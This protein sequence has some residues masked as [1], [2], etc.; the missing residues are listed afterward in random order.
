MISP[1]TDQ[2][3][4]EL[5]AAAKE[6]LLDDEHFDFDEKQRKLLTAYGSLELHSE[7]HRRAVFLC[8][9]AVRRVLRFGRL[10]TPQHVQD[11]ADAINLV[12]R[13]LVEVD[14]PSPAVWEKF[15]QLGSDRRDVVRRDDET[16]YL[17]TICFAVSALVRFALFAGLYDGIEALTYSW[18]A[19]EG[20]ADN[21]FD[22]DGFAR[23]MAES[24]IAAAYRMRFMSPEE[25]Y[26][27]H[28]FMSHV[29]V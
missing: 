21:A 12:K 20:D 19:D 22:E 3:P 5:L 23:W 27:G 10:S 4:I 8:L 29:D 11:M 24:A 28:K 25:L 14:E 26:S 13:W 6:Y 9:N 17:E 2:L 18:L 15:C 16:V 7:S 1:V